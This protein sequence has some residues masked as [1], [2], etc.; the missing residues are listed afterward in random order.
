MNYDN[1][2]SEGL[3]GTETLSVDYKSTPLELL[4]RCKQQSKGV[5]CGGLLR[6]GVVW[7]GET[8]PHLTRLESLIAECDLIL[9]I[10]TSSTV[11]PVAGFAQQ[12]KH[13]GGQ[14]AVFNIDS[15]Q[16]DSHDETDWWFEGP[17]EVTLPTL[18]KVD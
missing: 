11:Y 16:H 15:P 6:P 18:L 17:V 13:N 2:I 3:R 5:A 12:V 8:I 10:G 9:V 1:P 7:F 4:P 14:V